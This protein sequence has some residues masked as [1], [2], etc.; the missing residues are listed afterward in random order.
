M[1]EIFLRPPRARSQHQQLLA[2]PLAAVSRKS[3][4]QKFGKLK[5]NT[6][7]TTIM[8]TKLIST[9]VLLLV[10][11]YGPRASADTL[12]VSTGGTV[13]AGGYAF[14]TGYIF[15][16]KTNIW[17]NSLGY[18]TNA[19]P[20]SSGSSA[21]VQLSRLDGTVL[22]SANVATNS[23]VT[24]GYALQ[25]ITPVLL[26]AGQ[27]N[28]V[29]CGDFWLGDV[30]TNFPVAAQLT[31]LG[32]RVATTTN[33]GEALLYNGVNIGFQIATGVMPSLTSHPRSLTNLVGTTAFFTA[34][35]SGE[36]APAYQWRFN[37]TP[38]PSASNHVY[39][40]ARAGYTNAGNYDVVA[41]N[42]FGSVTSSVATL[43][44]LLPPAITLNG[45]ATITN[46]CHA[47]FTDPGAIATGTPLAIAGGGNHSL[48][49]KSDGT[50]AAWG[51]NT[52]GQTNI[53]VGLSNVVSIAGGNFHSL[54]LKSD[55]MVA[56]WGN[57]TSGQTN[58]PVGLSN[59][60][61]IAAGS[62]HNLALKGDGSVVAWGL[63]SFGQTNAPAS[64]SNVV[65][66]AAGFQH[67]LSLKSD[68]TLIAWGRN[69]FGQTNIPVSLSNVVA[70]AGGGNHS[71]ALKSD[72]KVVAWGDN[73]Y[74]QTNI[75]VGLSNV[76]AIA[77][78]N[79]HSLALKSDGKIV[80]WGYNFFGQTNIPVGLSNVVAVAGGGQHSLAL[81]SDGTVVA[82][83]DNGQ[84]QTNIP[85]GLNILLPVTVSGSVDTNT[86]GNYLL[87]YTATNSLGGS[88]TV[89]RT[90]LV[91]DTLPPVITL[92][93][94]NPLTHTMNLPF[95][96]PGATALDACGGS[97][98]VTTN[99]TVNIAFP[100]TYAVSYIATDSYGNSATN[101]RVVQVVAPVP[102]G[103]PP[104]ITLNG[105]AMLTNECHTAF[106]DPGAIATGAPL[107]IAAGYYHNLELKSDGT[108]A[109]WGA[110]TNNTGSFPNYGQSII[111]AGLSN[112]VAIAGGG[113]H[114]LALGSDGVVAAW[115]N[116]G[117]S[118]TSIPPGLSNVVAIAG[119]FTHSLALQSNGTVVAWGD[120]GSGQTNVPVGLSN[121]VAI[122]G[123]AY[124]SLVLKGDGTV[125]AWGLNDYGQTNV[126]A[127]LSNV[128]AI[129]AGAYHSLALRADGTVAAWG[130]NDL[131]QTN[132]PAGLSNVVSIAGGA[133]HS[134][135]LKGDGTVAVW[136]LNN[137]G[138]TN[139]PASLSNVVAITGGVEHNLALKSDG[140]AVAWGNNGYGQT[141]IPV[142]L[143]VS[144]P[145]TVSGSVD[146]NTPGSYTLTYSA[147]NI[148][149][150][151]ATT[152]RTVV[153]QDTLPPVIT[154]LGANP[155]TSLLNVPFVDPGATA[156]D[157]C[158]GSLPV[159][160]NNAVNI[161]VPGNYFVTYTATDSYGNAVT[162]IRTVQVVAPPVI[163]SQTTSV[164]IPCPGGST[165]LSVQASGTAP[166]NYAWYENVGPVNGPPPFGLGILIVPSGTNNLTVTTSPTATFYYTCVISN[167]LGSVASAT[168]PVMVSD[169][170][171]PVITSALPTNQTRLVPLNQ[172]LCGDMVND[173]SLG[174]TATDCT[175]VTWSQTPPAGSSFSAGT[176]FV[177]LTARDALNNE[178]NVSFTVTLVDNSPPA[179]T[180]QP[181][182][183]LIRRPEQSAAFSVT[184]TECGG[185][186]S[187]QWR[188]D[189]LAI[190][191]ATN[192]SFSIPFI[193]PTNAG[194]YTA[195]LT[196]S[197]GSITSSVGV[198][199]V[200]LPFPVFVQSPSNQSV[201]PG[202]SATFSGSA[203]N[204]WPSGTL[205]YQWWSG[206]A[207]VTGAT[208]TVY[209]IA[210]ASPGNSG[211]Y[212]LVASNL[213]AV[214]TSAVAVLTVATPLGAQPDSYLTPTNTPFAIP[215]ASLLAND[216][217]NGAV[218]PAPPSSLKSIAS[219]SLQG[220]T[221]S[222]AISGGLPYWTNRHHGP[223]NVDGSRRVATDGSGNVIVSGITKVT[224][225]SPGAWD[226]LTI[227]YSPTV[228]PL[229]TNVFDVYGAEDSPVALLADTNGNIFVTGTGYSFLFSD[230][231]VTR[232]YSTNGSVLW[233]AYY[234]SPAN[235]GDRPTS[236]TRDGG[237]NVIV[238]GNVTIKYSSS[239]VA[240][241][242]NQ[243]SGVA[244]ATD[245]S[246]NVFVVGTS[247]GGLLVAKYSASGTLVWTNIYKGP[248]NV[249]DVAYG[250][251]VGAD[252]AAYIT[253]HSTGLGTG[254]DIVALKYASSG[255]PLWTN[256]FNGPANGS[257]YPSSVNSVK[258]GASGRVFIAGNSTGS[259]T[260]QDYVVLAFSSNGIPL[261]TNRYDGPANNTDTTQELTLDSAG[262][263]IVTGQSTGVSS[264]TDFATVAYSPDGT[265]LWTNRFNGPANGYDGA[266]SISADTSGNVV[267]VGDSVGSGGFGEITTIKYG[268]Q[269]DPSRIN[270]TPPLNFFG[271]DTF[272]YV[273]TNSCGLAYTGLV[274]I[275]VGSSINVV[276]GES[277]PSGAL[278]FGFYGTP[279]APYAL[280]RSYSLTPPVVWS[281]QET[282]TAAGNGALVFTNTPVAATNNFWRIRSVP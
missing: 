160:S 174:M 176:N 254:F 132:I 115:G 253:G 172:P 240:Q 55:G 80:A 147:T 39:R 7:K 249:V 237:G 166:L 47:A 245:G 178:T 214:S 25:A 3:K 128:V 97:M 205:I 215:I 83:G 72:G 28:I 140:S 150:G 148:L 46:E 13:L 181:A 180:Q 12:G 30:L 103:T 278:R 141:T 157:A 204:P 90:V 167:S 102:V 255:Q 268:T 125:A 220:G 120:N 122:A 129:A 170:T 66:I 273:L 281:P 230:D 64:L 195:V 2:H 9:L 208:N 101:T 42:T 209:T 216:A 192:T 259:G 33:F 179:I 36:P 224:S 222:Y 143:S 98:A 264:G 152:T 4:K 85:S 236:L 250:L 99:S 276:S 63:N 50:V 266:A 261:W 194:S 164:S 146:T 44:V 112:V 21:L 226:M 199:T 16:P 262:N 275:A 197:G 257:D 35:A 93:G 269:P 57:N 6:G 248:T 169:T 211:N 279:G 106:T 53:P 108:V 235:T 127:D 113:Y 162:N 45:S 241:W 182:A 5:S 27:T 142:G 60:V 75:P 138:Q 121:G 135:A 202:C 221:V 38:I 78:G 233:T 198:L 130:R 14:G 104:V 163:L 191:G 96:D 52:S 54:A 229:W 168:I 49:L 136:G 260:G 114:S 188:K 73:F 23:P 189:G 219:S 251:A 247:I 238:S 165:N 187:V 228:Q 271:T 190:S 17:V 185:L 61:G 89:T 193:V 149:G 118:Q 51:N 82:W 79:A 86:P 272:T 256:R 123:G 22:A 117:Q 200:E 207:P 183:H 144:L 111:P 231:Y 232:K 119:G 70:I 88:G 124:H 227:K 277:L 8:K 67:S 32:T 239:G 270:Y 116:N 265:G 11:G 69:D 206:G 274:T 184:A 161:A 203:T 242:T 131:G 107:A 68:G 244:V 280:D 43:T 105:D 196:S 258:L 65:A 263:V 56:V 217:V 134:L 10:A 173:F 19:N 201:T 267:V 155:L 171:P 126:P 234:N 29:Y 213:Y 212:W 210:V 95:V 139:V 77:L 282:N 151:I 225:L 186:F 15:S 110:G 48:A 145:V 100:G 252:G 133:Y 159:T 74:G 158:G 87:T 24:S 1:A 81:K 40:I 177:T 76:V 175:S 243:F 37:G 41:S 156:L 137:Y 154:V 109:A 94:A 18:L 71:L 246:D 218:P 153:V 84:G 34:A 91:R 26:P 20:L 31:Y 92:L 223:L 59:V 58:I 62:D